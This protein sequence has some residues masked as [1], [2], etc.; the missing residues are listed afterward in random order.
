MLS[1]LPPGVSTLPGDHDKTVSFTAY[2]T[3]HSV[4]DLVNEHPPTVAQL[5]D[6]AIRHVKQNYLKVEGDP[7][8]LVVIAIDDD[9]YTFYFNAEIEGDVDVDMQYADHEYI[10]EQVIEYIISELSS[11]HIYDDEIDLN[12]EDI[13]YTV[14]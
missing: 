9:T 4:Y 11:Y 3:I 14:V 2:I 13:D 12:V 6:Y 7:N 8:S 1:N 5:I 10:Q